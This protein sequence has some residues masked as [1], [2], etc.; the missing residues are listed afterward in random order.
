VASRIPS[1]TSR[2]AVA[3]GI[4]AVVAAVAFAAPPTFLT[5]Q[6]R[7]PAFSPNADNVQDREVYFFTLSDSARIGVAVRQDSLGV[8]GPLVDSLFSF[9]TGNVLSDSAEWLGVN[10]SGAKVPDGVYWITAT[11]VNVDGAI[12]ATPLQILLDTVAPRDTITSPTGTFVQSLVHQVTGRASDKN[13][14]ARL[15]ITLNAEGHTL[16]DTLCAPCATDTVPFDVGVPDSIA[17]TDTLRFTIDATDPAGNGRPRFVQ[18]VI[19]SLPPPA[20]VIDPIASPIE[21]DSVVVEGTASEAESVFVTLDGVDAG[22]ARVVAGSRFEVRLRRFAQGTHVV[23]AT[24]DDRAG[25][26]SPPSAPV[27]FVYQ[28]PLGVVVPER[29]RAGDY[30][31][32]NLTKPANAVLVRIYDLTGRL[33]RRL[34]DRAVGTVYEFAWDLRDEAGN[35]IGSGPYVLHVEAEYTDGS[36]LAKRVAAVVTR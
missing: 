28:E 6:L 25:N 7:F 3:L 32:V 21:R 35:P 2:I 30:L 19:D 16:S 26:V 11:A 34:E 18:V 10:G 5:S 12:D 20:P 24:S 1:R 17:A 31:Q 14:L 33:V 23:V 13:G 15:V 22:R 36:R 9:T 29:L 27:S 4:V 8:A